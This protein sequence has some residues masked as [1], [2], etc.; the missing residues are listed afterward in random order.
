M[1]VPMVLCIFPSIFI[2][3]LAPAV[4]NIVKSF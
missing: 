3:V 2:V 4:I 1:L